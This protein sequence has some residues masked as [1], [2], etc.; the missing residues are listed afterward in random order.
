MLVWAVQ[1]LESETVAE[2]IRVFS[3]SPSMGKTMVRGEKSYVVFSSSTVHE[4]NSISLTQVN[5]SIYLFLVFWR[6]TA[7]GNVMIRNMFFLS[8][9]TKN[10]SRILSNVTHFDGR[11]SAMSVRQCYK[12]I[13]QRETIKYI[14][15]HGYI[16]LFIWFCLFVC[17]LFVFYSVNQLCGVHGFN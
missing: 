16:Y 5:P 6:T 7:M 3:S 4:S 14:K 17:L 9:E 8:K 11:E 13:G 1:S 15:R 10:L 2:S 12:N